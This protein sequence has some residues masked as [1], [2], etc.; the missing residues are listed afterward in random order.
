[1]NATGAHSVKWRQLE[2]EKISFNCLVKEFLCP[3]KTS[4]LILFFRSRVF[5][6]KQVCGYERGFE[7][8]NSTMKSKTAKIELLK[9]SD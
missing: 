2:G 8:L 6:G 7:A 4:F 3:G 9:I 1:M 5:F